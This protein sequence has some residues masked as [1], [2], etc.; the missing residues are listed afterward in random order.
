MLEYL[1]KS[2]IEKVLIDFYVFFSAQKG[3]GAQPCS[4]LPFGVGYF[5]GLGPTGDANVASPAVF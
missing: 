2:M 5:V 4:R 1:I 3:G